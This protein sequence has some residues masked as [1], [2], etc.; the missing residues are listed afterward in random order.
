MKYESIK[1][2]ELCNFRR[3]NQDEIIVKVS[4][5]SYILVHLG[6][7]EQTDKN[8]RKITVNIFLSISSNIRFEARASRC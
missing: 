3:I 2:A 1:M 7:D 4:I 6:P 5:I 8:G